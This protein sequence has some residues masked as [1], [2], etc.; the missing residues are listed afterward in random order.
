MA[1]LLELLS[2]VSCTVSELFTVRTIHQIREEIE[3]ITETRE[4][5]VVSIDLYRL[6]TVVN[7]G[8]EFFR[9]LFW[10][11]DLKKRVRMVNSRLTFVTEIIV[12][13][14]NTFMSWTFDWVDSTTVTNEIFVNFFFLEFF[15]L[16]LFYLNIAFLDDLFL[17]LGD[18]AGHYLLDF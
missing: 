2:H 6:L 16:L 13:A 12:R 5:E 15:L 14:D 18:N 9:S 8:D 3:T 11:F 10:G 7:D 1:F 17:N 4:L